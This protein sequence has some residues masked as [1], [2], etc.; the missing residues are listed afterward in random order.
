MK[1]LLTPF[2]IFTL[3][4]LASSFLLVSC[5]DYLESVIP[6]KD[7]DVPAEDH[8]FDKEIQQAINEMMQEMKKVPMSGDPDVDFARLQIEHHEGA[9]EMANI[10][11]AYGH[12]PEVKELAKKTKMAN[13][14]S[15]ERLESFLESHG[16]PEPVQSAEYRMF[17]NEME[18]AMEKMELGFQA[19]PDTQ[20]PDLDFSELIIRHHLG[21]MDM[22]R[23]EL[24][25][26]HHEFTLDE[27]KMIIEG[28][29][30]EMIEFSEYI[31]EHGIP[32]E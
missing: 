9:I 15:K 11:L 31:N 23:V 26:G 12:E 27:A 13:Q 32:S 14:A 24:E 22:A 16:D 19:A 4:L 29:A 28:Q 21:A 20:D 3:S 30:Q 6:D 8:A 10:E 5:E 17:W 18:E 25:V 7:K 1:K 2:K